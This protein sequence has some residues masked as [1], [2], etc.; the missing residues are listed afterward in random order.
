MHATVT[1]PDNNKNINLIKIL[2]FVNYVL[3]ILIFSQTVFLRN[4]NIIPQKWLAMDYY[5]HLF[6]FM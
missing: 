2:G 1:S 5:A 6:S 4:K 3:I